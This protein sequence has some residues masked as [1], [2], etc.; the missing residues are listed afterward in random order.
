MLLIDELDRADDE[1]EA[2]L[3]EFLSDFTVTIPEL[4]TI[5]AP[6]PPVVVITSNRT[7]EL[8]DALKRRCLFH[9]IDF[10]TVERETEII[11][12]RVPGIG[13]ALAAGVARA[14]ARL[15]ELGLVKAPGAAEAVDWARALAL[16]GADAV[17]EAAAAD[18]LGWIVKTREDLETVRA[19]LHEVVDA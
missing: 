1:F 9:W 4:G 11:E 13:P 18:S 16:L 12:L 10:P 19:S 5:A 7:R 14:V 17:T 8:H 2:F 15:R 3:L 6:S